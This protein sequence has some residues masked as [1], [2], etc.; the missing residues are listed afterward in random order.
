MMTVGR[1]SELEADA[2]GST[3]MHPHQNSEFI[4]ICPPHYLQ[5]ISVFSHHDFK[6]I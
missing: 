4:N 2:R 3:H 1:T 6:M 5:K